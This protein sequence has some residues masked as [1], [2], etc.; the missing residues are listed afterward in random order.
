MAACSASRLVGTAADWLQ[1]GGT[2]RLLTYAWPPDKSTSSTSP[3]I[4]APRVPPH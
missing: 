1:L 2:E 4:T 3:I